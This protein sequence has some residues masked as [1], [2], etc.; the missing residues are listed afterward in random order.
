[1]TKKWLKHSSARVS[2]QLQKLP[3]QGRNPFLS[4][5]MTQSSRRQQAVAQHQHVG[6]ALFYAKI[7]LWLSGAFIECSKYRK[8][9]FWLTGPRDKIIMRIKSR[10]GTGKEQQPSG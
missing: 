8:N 9:H 5:L 1:M 2:K 10:N 4:V 3:R 7:P 6:P